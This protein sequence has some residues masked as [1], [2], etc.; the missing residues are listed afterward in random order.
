MNIEYQVATAAWTGGGR[1][2]FGLVVHAG[3]PKY[4]RPHSRTIL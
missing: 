4:Q 1:I 2:S 3:Y